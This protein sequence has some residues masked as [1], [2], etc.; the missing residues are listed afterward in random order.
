MDKSILNVVISKFD[1]QRKQTLRE[2]FESIL[3][4]ENISEIF[5]YL[6]KQN[7]LSEILPE[8]IESIGLEQHTPHH[9]YTV[10]KHILMVVKNI[11]DNGKL[12][13]LD[14]HILLWVAL[15]HDIGKPTALKK[16]LKQGF[17][18]FTN[19]AIYSAKMTTKI[20]KRFGFKHK[21]ISQIKTIVK[22]HEFFRYIRLYNMGDKGNRMS[23]EYVFNTIK[24]VGQNNFRLMLPLYEADFMAQSTFNRDKKRLI[25]KCARQMFN[26]YLQAK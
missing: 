18:K 21:E 6:Y 7:I 12:G 20:L 24:K 13:K 1:L 16:N 8:F 23:T 22:N 19:H 11:A 14:K 17:Y 9:C 10:D 26:Y 15:L 3:Q 25:L 2:N 5:D 4:S